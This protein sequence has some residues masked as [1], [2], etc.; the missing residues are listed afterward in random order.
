MS[1]ATAELVGVLTFL[2]PGFVGA[3]V[4][5]ALTSHPRPGEFDRVVQALVFTTVAQAMTWAA[6]WLASL[7]WPT[8]E[9]PAGLELLVAVAGA[10]GLALLAATISNHDAAHRLLR[11]I[12]ITRET[13]YPSGW[14]S[15]FAQNPRSYVILHL[16]DDR[17]LYGWPEEWPGS[18]ATGY[19]RITEAL[20]LNGAHDND[21]MQETVEVLVPA[22]SVDMV[23]FLQVSDQEIAGQ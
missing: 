8:Y 17:R 14:Y 9:W 11:R 12:G 4:F 20:W 3:A 19:F 7:R 21:A 18:S 16:Q 6:R 5:Y 15:G 13:S 23:Q 10:V 2:L 22:D 1:W